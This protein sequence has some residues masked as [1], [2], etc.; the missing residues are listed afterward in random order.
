MRSRVLSRPYRSL[1]LAIF[2]LNLGMP[3]VLLLVLRGDMIFRGE[4]D[5]GIG[6]FLVWDAPGLLVGVCWVLLGHALR[7]QTPI[8]ATS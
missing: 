7:E 5:V 8:R 2:A 6:A 3:L 4:P 1:P